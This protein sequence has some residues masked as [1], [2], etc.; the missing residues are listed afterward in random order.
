[1]YLV[2]N[3]RI[4]GLE[5][6]RERQVIDEA[7]EPGALS[8]VVDQFNTDRVQSPRWRG[9]VGPAP[10]LRE[11]DVVEKPLH[12]STSTSQPKYVPSSSQDR[13]LIRRRFS[14]VYP[15]RHQTWMKASQAQIR[16]GLCCFQRSSRHRR[17]H[18]RLPSV[19][20]HLP[21]ANTMAF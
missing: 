7:Q 9:T 4:S 16:V 10:R 19:W 17:S 1:V 18:Q 15:Q 21:M 5:I 20:G 2:L 13:M 12:P 14:V 8:E 6:Y 11:L 3:K